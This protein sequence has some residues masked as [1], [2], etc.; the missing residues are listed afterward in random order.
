METYYFISILQKK[1][2]WSYS[3]EYNILLRSHR[4]PNK[5]LSGRCRAIPNDFLLRCFLETPKN[6]GYDNY[7][8]LSIKTLW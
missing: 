6:A 3:T 4:L 8:W 7:M 2:N 5:N 1:F